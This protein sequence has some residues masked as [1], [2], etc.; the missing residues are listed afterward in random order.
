MHEVP[1]HIQAIIP[2]NTILVRPEEAGLR[3]RIA[4]KSSGIILV[5]SPA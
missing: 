3:W 1:F 2:D 5:V 4:D